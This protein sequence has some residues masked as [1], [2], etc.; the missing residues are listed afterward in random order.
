M[1]EIHRLLSAK[2][3]R[4]IYEILRKYGLKCH[5]WTINNI[6][7]IHLAQFLSY[8]VTQYFILKMLPH[9]SYFTQKQ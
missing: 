3:D 1:A 5:L 2:R 8:N 7:R 9:Y 6:T 4:Q